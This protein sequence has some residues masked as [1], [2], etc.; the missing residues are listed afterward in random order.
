LLWRWFTEGEAAG[1]LLA[2]CLILLDAGVCFV[3]R[4]FSRRPNPSTK[5]WLGGLLLYALLPVAALLVAARLLW[6]WFDNGPA[7]EWWLIGSL[8]LL[9]GLQTV[10]FFIEP[11]RPSGAPYWRW[12]GRLVVQV[13]LTASVLL[14]PAS[15]LVLWSDADEATRVL[16]AERT[17]NMTNGASVIPPLL[18]LAGGLFVSGYFARRRRELG[19]RFFIACPYP[20]KSP[21]PLLNRIYYRLHA[22]TEELRDDLTSTS[23]LF[24]R[25]PFWLIVAG[26]AYGSALLLILFTC[27]G[28]W[29][30]TVW[31][32]LFLAGFVWLSARNVLDVVRFLAGWHALASVLSQIALLPMVHAFD[33]MPRKVIDLFGG[34]LFTR[35]PRV[36]HLMLPLQVLRQLGHEVGGAAPA[37]PGPAPTGPLL[38]QMPDHGGCPAV[39]TACLAQVDNWPAIGQPLP[40]QELPRKLI[41]TLSEDARV[42]LAQLECYWPRHALSE[43]FGSESA[44]GAKEAPSGAAKSGGA[45]PAARVAAGEDTVTVQVVVGGAKQ[46][47][48]AAPADS[49]GPPPWVAK[50]ED[51]V[52]MQVVVFLSQ[53]VIQLRTLATGLVWAAALLLL[54]AASF[55]FQPERLILVI[56]L[57]LLLLVSAAIVWVLVQSN[58]NE[59]VSRITRSTPNRFELNAAFATSAFQYLGPIVVVL[60]A[61]AS[62]R[63]RVLLEPLINLVR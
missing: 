49:A 62:G 56:Q 52:A 60:L 24:G 6:R 42:I 22:S 23:A 9:A 55:P 1:G 59:I 11:P 47:A 54:A 4:Q 39:I 45:A 12:L 51:F 57:T 2:C 20:Q 8:L 58:R 17:V 40:E 50:A 31:D 36:A 27:R 53:F 63:L 16:F 61:G 18:M 5:A 3:V 48:P 21:N 35:R 32:A 19:Q 41:N 13:L 38:G 34:Y 46:A 43:A 33:R 10:Y 7:A 44:E 14:F 30:G 26:V 37:V 15:L 25:R 28:T 29:E